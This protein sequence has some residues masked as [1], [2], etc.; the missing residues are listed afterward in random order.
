[1]DLINVERMDA[2]MLLGVV[3]E[4]LRLECDNLAELGSKFDLN[5]NQLTHKLDG[6]GYHYQET[7][8]QFKHLQ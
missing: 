3:N 1:M 7:S 6:I 4:Q 5:L 8:N 2:N